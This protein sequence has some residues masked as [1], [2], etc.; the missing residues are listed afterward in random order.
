M[1]SWYYFKPTQRIETDEGIKTKSQRG[2]FVKNWW[3]TRWLTAMERVMDRGRLQRGRTYARQGQVLS[4][5]E[6]QGKITAQV[7]GS[8]RTPYKITIELQPLSG[9]CLGEDLAG[10]GRATHLCGPTVGWGDAP[11]D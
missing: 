10:F 8:R 5:E 4:L 6:K 1:M 9:A 3:A 2:D 7:Q 11:G